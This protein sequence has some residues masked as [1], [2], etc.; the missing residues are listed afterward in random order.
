MFFINLAWFKNLLQSYR[1]QKQRG[2]LANN[3]AGF[4]GFFLFISEWQLCLEMVQAYAVMSLSFLPPDYEINVD[5]QI[6]M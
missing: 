5:F 4:G 3:C 1:Q 6:R 2:A